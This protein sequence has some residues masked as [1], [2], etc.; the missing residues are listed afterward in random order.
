MPS[1]V[2]ELSLSRRLLRAARRENA[3]A[4]GHRTWIERRVRSLFLLEDRAQLDL[5]S[6]ENLNIKYRDTDKRVDLCKQLPSH[7]RP[8]GN[9]KTFS[10]AAL[11]TRLEKEE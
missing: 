11:N 1:S 5:A 4:K 10:P 9:D 3:K 8:Q 6:G 7:P 2:Y